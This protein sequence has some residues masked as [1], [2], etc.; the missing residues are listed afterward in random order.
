M[1]EGM[2]YPGDSPAYREA[3]DALVREEAGL[4]AAVEA[5]AAARRRLPLGQPL[6]EYRFLG[7][8]G[9]VALSELFPAQLDN[10]FL[11][12]FMYTG[13]ESAPCPMCSSFLDSLDPLTP[14]LRS[15][16]G[17]Y[18]LARAPLRD[19]EAVAAARGWRNHR[20]LSTAESEFPVEFRSQAPDGSQLPMAHVFVRRDGRVYHHWSSE[21]F[22]QPSDW[23][24]APP[25]S[26]L[27][28][29]ALPGSAPGRT[30]RYAPAS[31]MPTARTDVEIHYTS[32]GSD[33]E[34][35]FFCHGAG[36][37]RASW[38]QQ[39]GAFQSS[40]RC[41]AHDHRGFGLS[42]C[43]LAQFDPRRFAD[44]AV[45]VMDDAGIARAHFVCQSMGGWTGVR[46]APGASGSHRLP[47]VVRHHR[48]PSAGRRRS[49]HGGCRR[50][51]SRRG[52]AVTGACRRLSG[53]QPSGCGA[54]PGTG[55]VQR[56]THVRSRG[57]WQIPMC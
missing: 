31:L 37:N 19:L 41:L 21:L 30:G 29:V 53:E 32:W 8:D 57:D 15:R 13:G 38:W 46:M 36:G 52:R 56:V 28:V 24:P 7:A 49:S 11:Y 55:G 16:M 1:S 40:Y 48:W 51:R 12:S 35:V 23:H 27:A 25:G 45:A 33:D 20:F 39:I 4:R 26:A 5:V 34:C 47:R 42:A 2:D 9:E 22:F 54:L 14:S 6:Q 43:D 50:P 10:L 3:R 17:M 18:V 44:D